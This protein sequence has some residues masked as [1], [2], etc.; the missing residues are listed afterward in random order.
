MRKGGLGGRSEMTELLNC[1]M[2]LY[3]PLS[4]ITDTATCPNC[5]EDE[6]IKELEFGCD[7][8]EKEGE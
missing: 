8:N 4:P 7:C 6:R 1:V 2:S 5:K 3:C